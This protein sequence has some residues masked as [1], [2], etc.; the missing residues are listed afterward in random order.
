M[1]D[2]KEAI[3]ELSKNP[4]FVKKLAAISK[5]DA[6]KQTSLTVKLVNEFGYDFKEEELTE[7]ANQ[8]SKLSE[9]ELATV[10]GGKTTCFCFLGGGG[11]GG[12][13]DC[14]CAVVG[15]GIDPDG[16]SCMCTGGGG[17]TG[18]ND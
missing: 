6:A 13:W 17:G 7:Y 9:E 12:D 8:S 10:S 2:I 11:S 3:A 5:E 1:K 16:H 15:V 14:G 18:M 4:E